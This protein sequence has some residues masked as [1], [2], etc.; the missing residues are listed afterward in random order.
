MA[1]R[2]PSFH[3]IRVLAAANLIAAAPAVVWIA[4]TASDSV[5][6]AEGG[7]SSDSG[8]LNGD[9]CQFAALLNAGSLALSIARSGKGW[10]CDEITTNV[11]AGCT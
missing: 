9:G 10:S 6:N 4:C 11:G 7:P 3:V 8:N 2:A 1:L 5:S